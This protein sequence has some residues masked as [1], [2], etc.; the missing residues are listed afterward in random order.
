MF[1]AAPLAARRSAIEPIL[2]M[3]VRVLIGEVKTALD[4]DPARSAA[5]EVW[6]CYERLLPSIVD[7]L[8]AEERARVG[9][10]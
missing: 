7:A 5:A 6:A 10:R 9:P 4:R 8:T 2:Y 3:L 1:G